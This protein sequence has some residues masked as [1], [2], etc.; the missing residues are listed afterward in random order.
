MGGVSGVSGVSSG[1]SGGG[2]PRVP[3]PTVS[4]GTLARST[5]EPELTL[6]WFAMHEDE[7]G[8]LVDGRVEEEEV[9]DYLHERLVILLGSLLNTWE[10][11]V[12]RVNESG[13]ES[14]ERLW[15]G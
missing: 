7:P 15:K 14:L 9:P 8:E 6:D 5:T 11:R 4:Q 12:K 13:R 10:R 3:I 2:A 1:V